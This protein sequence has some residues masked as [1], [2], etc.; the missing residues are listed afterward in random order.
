MSGRG[1]ITLPDNKIK[2]LGKNDSVTSW[3]NLSSSID[4]LDREGAA[5]ALGYLAILGNEDER[6]RAINTLTGLLKDEAYEVRRDAI[7]SLV[8]IEAVGIVP[9]LQG[10]VEKDKN[11]W[12]QR[13]AQWG[14]AE[15]G[16]N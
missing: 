1:T 8:K 5:Q 16:R 9:M 12:V 6:L 4:Q 13:V 14:V 15:L 2:D 10:M 11:E 3:I 7:E